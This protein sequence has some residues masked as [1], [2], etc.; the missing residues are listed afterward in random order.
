[1]EP[2]SPAVFPSGWFAL[3]PLVLLGAL[4][5]WFRPELLRALRPMS[6]GAAGE[7]KVAKVLQRLFAEVLNDVILP[8]GRGGLTQID[9]LA[10]TP[11][12]LVVVETKNY[13]GSIFGQA[14]E[15]TWTQ[16]IGHQRNRFQNPLYQNFAH[17]EAVKFHAP[18]V[19][20]LER[21]VFIDQARFPKGLPD[22]VVK[23]SGLA[24]SLRELR[25]SD[26]PAA[27]RLAWEHV[28]RAVRW[29]AAAKAEHLDGLKAR[30]PE[31]SGTTGRRL[32][33][34]GWTLGKAATVMVVLLGLSILPTIVPTA[35]RG[36]HVPAQGKAA[37]ERT[38]RPVPAPP[39]ASYRIV[40]TPTR[41]ARARPAPPIPN[42]HPEAQR[43]RIRWAEPASR[44]TRSAECNA[45][46]AA[47][48][49]DNSA[50]RRRQRDQLCGAAETATAAPIAAGVAGPAT[51]DARGD[52]I[53]R[54]AA[55]LTR[56]RRGPAWSNGREPW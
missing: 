18:G 20:V 8:D 40:R 51:N 42:H 9:H 46:I 6:R 17:T 52:R 1:M 34:P 44:S 23:L 36:L 54:S 45:A 47:V 49:V 50:K 37:S 14:R 41:Q 13:G 24:S 26:I 55:E 19:A 4:L 28:R 5:G 29:D 10:L 22:G 31:K 3:S 16:A 43:P 2:P 39:T 33:L 53:L 15:P 12:G 27:T 56:D 35:Y 30:Y 38:A 7:A 11:A 21:V 25:G 32:P 48:L